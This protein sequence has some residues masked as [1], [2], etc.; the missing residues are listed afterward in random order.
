[1]TTDPR[2]DIRHCPQCGAT[3]F[4]RRVPKRDDRVRLICAGCGYIHYVGP[5]LAAGA[6]LEDG[7]RIC[8]V[9][10]AWD[11]GRGLWT[12]PGGFVDLDEDAA[13]A[14]AR[15]VAEETGYTAEIGRLVGVYRSVGPKGKRVVIVVYA[16]RV[17]GKSETH[18]EEVQEVRW[19]GRD[20]IPWD[21]FAFPSTADALRD[22]LLG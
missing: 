18:A 3:D 20:E 14:A 12:F 2:L 8:L 6:I 1:V 5:A 4:E 17:G 10:R 15:E 9:R 7:G 13:G 16:A 19:F 22:Y 11:P 21:S